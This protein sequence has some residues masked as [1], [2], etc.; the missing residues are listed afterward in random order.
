MKT[1]ELHD[2]EQRCRALFCDVEALLGD[3]HRL[4]AE[5]AETKKALLEQSGEIGQLYEKYEPGRRLPEQ[6]KSTF[7]VDEVKHGLE[8]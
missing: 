4:R 5:L 6:L 1:T 7:N 3:N 8:I 2:A